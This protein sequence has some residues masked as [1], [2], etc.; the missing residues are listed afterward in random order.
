[1]SLDQNKSR[2]KIVVSLSGGLDSGVLLSEVIR[3]KF[4]QAEE[5]AC[6][7]FQYRSVHNKKELEAATKLAQ[8][9][10]CAFYVQNVRSFIDPNGSS[11]LVQ[12]GSGQI[13]EGHYNEASMKQTVVPGRNLIFAALMAGFAESFGA[14][15]IYMGVHSGDHYIYPDCRPGFLNS[16]HETIILSSDGKINFYAPF[17]GVSKAK[18]VESGLKTG[19]PFEKTWTCYKG[20]EQ[21]CGVCGSCQERLEAFSLNGVEDPLPYVTRELIAKK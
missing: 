19:F 21:A 1:M 20:G 12:G 2:Y 13:P 17:V 3:L 11:V 14:N 9:F 5:V 4:P 8:H 18:I 16:L 15:E 7:N 10:G 6:L